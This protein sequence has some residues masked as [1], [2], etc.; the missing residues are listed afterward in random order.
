MMPACVPALLRPLFSSAYLSYIYPGFG[1][2]EIVPNAENNCK[3]GALLWFQG[4]MAYVLGM[5]HNAV[6]Q[7]MDD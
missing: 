3:D 7:R 6:E 2:R 5:Q 4:R 1:A